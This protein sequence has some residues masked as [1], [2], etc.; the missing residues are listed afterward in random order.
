MSCL[1][2]YAALLR[3]Y[4]DGLSE[5]YMAP[6][7]ERYRLLFDQLCRLLVKSSPFNLEIPAPFRVTAQRYLNEDEATRRQMD[8]A[9]NRNF[10][11][12]DLADFIELKRLMAAR[13]QGGDGHAD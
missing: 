3:L 4:G 12:S 13:R 7:D 2:D 5:A 9:E 8:R 1:D 11:V 10:M 6:N